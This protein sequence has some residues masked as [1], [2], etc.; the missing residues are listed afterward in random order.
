MTF[1]RAALVLALATLGAVPGLA[2]ETGSM[3]QR[4]RPPAKGTSDTYVVTLS[5]TGALEP[6]FPGSDKA[7]GNFFPS[8]SYRRSDEPAR[9]S[10]VDDGISISIID[11]P[12][13]RV[14]PVFRY[15]SG[16]FLSDDRRLFGLRKLDFDIESGLFIEYWPLTFIRARIEARHGFR[17]SSG[18]V[19]NAGVDL[20]EPYGRFVF[21]AGPRIY[22]G[23]QRYVDRYFGVRPTEALLNP[24]KLFP[25]R[26]DGGVTGVGALGAVTY[27]F[28][29]TWAATGYI[30]Y[31]RL[32]GDVADS[33]IVRRIGSSDQITLGLKLSYSFQ[34]D[35][36]GTIFAGR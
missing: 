3:F 4:Y 28:S 13:F 33:P 25:F 12:T 15:Q 8:L 17:E 11:D 24:F 35:A 20:V 29:E 7:S 31:K 22:L 32:V 23:D 21:S 18:F 30:N 16:R 2:Q 36:A 19:G 34:Y 26:P 14:G 6:R 1:L 9:F 27:T 10:S 5:A